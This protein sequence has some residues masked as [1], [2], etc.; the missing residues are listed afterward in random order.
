MKGGGW[1][2]T[3]LWKGHGPWKVENLWNIRRNLCSFSNGKFWRKV[4]IRT[5]R[6]ENRVRLTDIRL[7]FTR[8]VFRLSRFTLVSVGPYVDTGPKT[9]IKR[10]DT[11]DSRLVQCVTLAALARET[12]HRVLAPSVAANAG[13]LDALVDVFAVDKPGSLEKIKTKIFKAFIPFE[14]VPTKG[15]GASF[16]TIWQVV[17]KHLYFWFKLCI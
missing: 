1:T 14:R 11:P 10:T 6:I 2:S 17:Q 12:A 4:E 13:K 5:V 3:I 8:H 9:T 16:V 15:S 7:S